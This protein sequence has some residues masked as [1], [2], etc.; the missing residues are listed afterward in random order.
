MTELGDGWS[1]PAVKY[2][3]SRMQIFLCGFEVVLPLLR[4]YVY[5][6][7]D[8]PIKETFLHSATSSWNRVI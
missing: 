2:D 5:E 3:T 6:R 8:Y 7:T 4:L 1:Q